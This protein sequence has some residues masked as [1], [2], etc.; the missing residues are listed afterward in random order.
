MATAAQKLAEFGYT[1]EQANTWLFQQTD[2]Q[3]VLS[4]FAMGGLTNAMIGE[5]AGYPGAPYSAAQ[6]SAFFSLYGVDS[7]VLDPA[8]GVFTISSDSVIEGGALSHTVALDSATTFETE[9]ALDIALLSAAVADFTDV[10]VS[11]GVKLASFSSIVVPAGVSSFTITFSTSNDSSDEAD[12]SYNLSVGGVMATGAIIDNDGAVVE[13]P[14]E[15]GGILPDNLMDLVSLLQLNSRSGV[16]SNASLKAAV[17]AQTGEA[18]YLATFTP[19]GVDGGEDGTWTTDELG[20]THLGN[21]PATVATIESLF[22]GTWLHIFTSIDQGEAT[23]LSDFATQNQAGLESGDAAT[24][25]L[26]ADLILAAM[27]DPAPPL[28]SDAMLAQYLLV[29][30]IVEMVG[31]VASGTDLDIFDYLPIG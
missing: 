2:P 1:M 12:E 7:T 10:S 24:F 9:Y 19:D 4:V 3:Y 22:Y 13:P 17:V 6:V 28:V 16:L 23:Q 25:E 18:N 26:Y 15:D 14:D 31:Q 20:F 11:N 30:V 8:P 27:A 29:P 5:I 21:L